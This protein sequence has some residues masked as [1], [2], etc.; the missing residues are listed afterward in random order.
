MRMWVPLEGSDKYII[1]NNGEI[2]NI[3]RRCTK[4][5]LCYNSDYIRVTLKLDGVRRSV[6]VHKYM[7]RSFKLQKIGYPQCDHMDGDKK[8]NTL[9]NLQPAN[10]RTQQTTAKKLGRG[11]VRQP[12]MVA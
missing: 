1:S 11:F 6:L 5:K 9:V 8:N 12:Q 4:L 10:C 3:Q 7:L 2:A